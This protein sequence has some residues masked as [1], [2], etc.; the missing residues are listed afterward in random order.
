VALDVSVHVQ[1]SFVLGTVVIS[2][3]RCLLC[4]VNSDEVGLR[5]KTVESTA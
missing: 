2:D 3:G 1:M 4:G 5:R